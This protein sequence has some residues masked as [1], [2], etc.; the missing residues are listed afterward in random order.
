MAVALER[1]LF[2]NRPV[3]RYWAWVFLDSFAV[4]LVGK[5]SSIFLSQGSSLAFR[6][7]LMTV[8]FAVV[9][10]FDLICARFAG[11]SYTISDLEAHS[12]PKRPV[13]V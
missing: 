3:W 13:P 10:G 4:G 8:S 7:F 12:R 5:S 1:R 9:E 2:Q 6:P 11:G